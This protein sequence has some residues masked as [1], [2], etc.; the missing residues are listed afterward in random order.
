GGRLRRRAGRGPAEEG[1][2]A[3]VARHACAGVRRERVRLQARDRVAGDALRVARTEGRDRAHGVPP[4]SAAALASRRPSPGGTYSP[5]ASTPNAS[6]AGGSTASQ[7]SRRAR[8][9][10]PAGSPCA[11]RST[12]AAMPTKTSAS[13]ARNA[14]ATQNALASRADFRIVS[15]L[16]NRPNGGMPAIARKP[17]TQS[18]PDAGSARSAP[19]TSRLLFVPYAASRLPAVRNSSPLA[20]EWL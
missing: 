15:S 10:A 12:T 5:S 14:A 9:T 8:G 3:R 2:D 19:R 11:M 16:R 4:S 18:V 13:R 17:T 6:S 1:D 20:S 7:R